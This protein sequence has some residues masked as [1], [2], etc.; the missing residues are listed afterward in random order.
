MKALENKTMD[1][2]MEMD[3]LE[4][5]DEIR[6][7]NAIHQKISAD[8]LLEHHLEQMRKQNEHQAMERT[9]IELG[10]DDEELLDMLA[11]RERGEYVQR[12]EDEEQ[13]EEERAR[14]RRKALIDTLG[15]VINMPKRETADSEGSASEGFKAPLPRMP[16]KSKV[17]ASTTSVLKSGVQVQLRVKGTASAD[18]SSSVV[19][20]KNKKSD[21]QSAPIV[22]KGEGSDS[23]EDEN[24]SSSGFSLVSY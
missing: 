23:D 4:G 24:G 13:D 12:L 18:S 8:Q 2:K 17:S 1:S 9:D 3:I 7:V 10:D 21:N 16:V 6:T 14:K 11:Q 19:G 15:P 5:L 20:D 22:V